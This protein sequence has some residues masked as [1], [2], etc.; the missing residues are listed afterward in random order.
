MI[1]SI[2]GTVFIKR[3]TDH[4]DTISCSLVPTLQGGNE[5]R[6]QDLLKV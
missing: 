1:I 4:G 5:L 6:V 3:A 2:L